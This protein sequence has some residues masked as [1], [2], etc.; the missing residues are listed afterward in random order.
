MAAEGGGVIFSGDV[1]AGRLLLLIQALLTTQWALKRKK[2][3]GLEEG[4][5][6]QRENTAR[7]HHMYM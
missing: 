2:H 4:E 3:E 6:Q 1:A 7:I 5:G